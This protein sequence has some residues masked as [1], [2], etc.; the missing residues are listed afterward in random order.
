MA[1]SRKTEGVHDRMPRKTQHVARARALDMKSAEEIMQDTMSNPEEVTELTD[2]ESMEKVVGEATALELIMPVA[3][4]M[5]KSYGGYGPELV[6]YASDVAPETGAAFAGDQAG[7]VAFVGGDD[8]NLD[9][10]WFSTASQELLDRSSTGEDWVAIIND[11]ARRFSEFFDGDYEAFSFAVDAFNRRAWSMGL[12]E[13]QLAV[14]N[15]NRFGVFGNFPKDQR[16]VPAGSEAQFADFVR[17]RRLAE[18]EG[19]LVDARGTIRAAKR[20]PRGIIWVNEVRRLDFKGQ[21][22]FLSK[23]DL[24]EG[25]FS[26]PAKMKGAGYVTITESGVSRPKTSKTG[27]V[28]FFFWPV[29]G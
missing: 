5:L 13:S 21:R 27:K 28:K 23:P 12:V 1:G 7:N 20:G 26:Y 9:V 3:Q 8:F 4:D 29:R 19:W 11:L 24:M 15:F 10:D 22:K 2:P 25:F 6:S 17:S 16:A 14:D 18:K